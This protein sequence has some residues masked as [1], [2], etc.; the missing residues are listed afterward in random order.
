MEKEV[1]DQ[2]GNKEVTKGNQQ[3]NN[4]EDMEISNAKDKAYSLL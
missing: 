3:D 2:D 4:K 1:S